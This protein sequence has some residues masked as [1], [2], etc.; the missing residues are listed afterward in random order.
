[1]NSIFLNSIFPD[2][3]EFDQTNFFDTRYW[4]DWIQSECTLFRIFLNSIFFQFETGG[5]L[6]VRGEFFNSITL[7]ELK[8]GVIKTG[9]IVLVYPPGQ[10]PQNRFPISRIR[11]KSWGKWKRGGL[12]AN[13]SS[14]LNCS[15][16]TSRSQRQKRKLD[17][18]CICVW[19]KYLDNKGVARCAADL[20]GTSSMNDIKLN[21]ELCYYGKIFKIYGSPFCTIVTSEVISM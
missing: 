7:S 20:H 19:A 10:I 11:A 21:G 13:R 14:I 1:M 3:F 16:Q 4:S 12:A 2:F 8:R 15:Q 18:K 6:F 9:L 17:K 5:W